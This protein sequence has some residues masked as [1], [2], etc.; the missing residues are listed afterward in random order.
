MHDDGLRFE[1]HGADRLRP[2]LHLYVERV[3]AQRERRRV[4]RRRALVGRQGHGDRDAV[5]ALQVRG[6]R[7]VRD[8]LRD[9]R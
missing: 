1:L 8:E 4:Q 5:R 6:R 2:R 3:R 9:E 7:P